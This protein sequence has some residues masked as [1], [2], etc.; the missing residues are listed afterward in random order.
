VV[1]LWVVLAQ[2]TLKWFGRNTQADK[3]LF[4]FIGLAFIALA[5][6]VPVLLN[7]TN[8]DLL[9]LFHG[10]HSSLEH[11]THE[12]ELYTAKLSHLLLE[13]LNKVIVFASIAMSLY[14]FRVGHTNAKNEVILEK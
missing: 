4:Y 3:R 9:S 6:L 11:T 8:N 12:S 14:A 13:T 7:Y 1:I 2:L 10:A 5:V